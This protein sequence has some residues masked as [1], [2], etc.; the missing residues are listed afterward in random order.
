M[1]NLFPSVI[2]IDDT[3]HTNSE[4][5][6]FMT[7]TAMTSSGKAFTWLRAFLPNKTAAC[8]RWVF[9]C[10]MPLLIG[11][12]ILQKIKL[13]ITDGDSQETT[14]LDFAIS[15]KLT[16][17]FRVRCGWHI[18]EKGWQKHCP[19]ERSV[20][21][22]KRVA[23]KILIKTIKNWLYSWM[24]PGFCESEDEY[25]V[26]KVLFYHY[27]NSDAVLNICGGNEAI[28]KQIIHQLW[29]QVSCFCCFTWA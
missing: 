5:R 19:G 16:G 12:K 23:Y 4:K 29:N 22:S 21:T 25:H 24:R 10:V 11:N 14:Q 20:E 8:F 6:P 18:I 3:S 7:F 2:K 1:L 9:R 17:L 28:Q 27:M 13:V 26:S 15:E